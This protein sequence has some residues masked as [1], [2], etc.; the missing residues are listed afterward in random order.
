[1]ARVSSASTAT[2]TK[3]RGDPITVADLRAL[4]REAELRQLPEAA[5]LRTRRWGL[6]R[7]VKFLQL[8]GTHDASAAPGMVTGPVTG[9]LPVQP[10]PTLVQSLFED[11]QPQA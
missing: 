5:V 3:R 9:S 8:H 2:V 1:M 10:A 6:R 7:R 11:R 4:I